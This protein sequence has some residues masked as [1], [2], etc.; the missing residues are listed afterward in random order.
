[1]Y[2]ALKYTPIL[3]QPINMPSTL[4]TQAREGARERETQCFRFRLGGGSIEALNEAS[5][6]MGMVKKE[7]KKDRK[8]R[9]GVTV[10]SCSCVPHC[11][12]HDVVPKPCGSVLGK[13]VG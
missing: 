2:T 9:G 8:V 12:P 5:F 1:M 7:R 13:V 4:M 3:L 11:V 6:I 10:G